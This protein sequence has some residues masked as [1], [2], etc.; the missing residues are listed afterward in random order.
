MADK[1]TYY[2]TTAIAYTSGKPHIGNTYEAVLADSIVRF[3]RLQGYDVRFQT[4]TDEHGQKIELKA[5]E[6]GITPKQFVDDVSGEIRS[7]WDLMGTS[8]DKFIRTTDDYHEKQVQKIFKKLYDRGDIYKGHY[9]GMYCTPCES[10]FTASQLVDG[11]CPDCGRECQPAKEEAYFLKL[12]KYA[13]RLIEHINTHPE[14]IQPESRK[15]EM[16]NNFLLPGLQDLCVSRTSFQ[17]GIPVDFDPGHVVYVWIDALSNYITGLGFDMDGNHTPENGENLYDKFWPA[18][19]HL[20]GKDILRFHTIYWPIMLMALGLPLPK[21][22]FGHPWLLQGD[23]KMSK[24]KG[25]VIYADDLV[26]IFGVDAVRYFVLHEMPFE[27]DGVISWELMVERMNSDLANVLG[28]LVNRTISMTNKYLGGVVAD[29]GA[30]ES[31]DDELKAKAVETAKIV[32]EKMDRLRVADAIT[33]IF[34]LFKRCNKYI[35]ETE[36]WILGKDEAKK[37]R[38][39]TVLYNLVEAITIGASLLEAFMPGT[40]EK[41]LSQLNTQ[42]RGFEDMGT[43][44]QTPS[45]LKVTEKP[46]ILFM[47]LDPKEVMAKAEEIKQKQIAEAKA[48]SGETE[49]DSPVIDIE[50]KAEITFDDFMKMQFQVGEIIACEE[51]KKSKKLLCSQVRVGSEVKQIVS[52]IKQYYSAEEMVG[53]KV[54]VLVNLKP[55]KLAGVLSEG[56]LLCAEDAEGNLA[57]V[58]PEKP[59]PAGAEIC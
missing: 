13:D 42:K 23:G 45:G 31:V 19:L 27:N 25:N 46:E 8:Y 34:S 14:F 38:L 10:F 43:F 59:M 51:V 24:S 9:E 11:K 49:E 53:K 22:V 29:K 33:E 54:M 2:L 40:T 50:P 4:G 52:G 32:S 57:L 7:I 6:A 55:A 39:S 41:I 47:R 16:M 26:D 30:A 1:K 12:S 17:W 56:M 3:K 48:E 44:G 35:D 18:D 28:N 15:N 21:Q 5:E 37:D 58:V 20:I 36:P